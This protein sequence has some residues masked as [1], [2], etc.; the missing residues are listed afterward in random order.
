MKENEIRDVKKREF[1]KKGLFA[2][3]AG[4]LA[5]LFSKIG[6]V[7]AERR[8]MTPI[9]PA[10]GGTGNAFTKFTGPT[11]TEKTFTL[12]DASS[13]I[14]VQSGALGTP[15]SGTLSNCTGLPAAQGAS[16]VLLSTITASNS[17][18]VDVETTF[19]STYDCYVLKLSGFYGGTGGDIL[20]AR[21]KIGGSYITT[22]TYPEHTVLTNSGAI[23]YSGTENAA[24][25]SIQLTD[26]L[27][28][29][30]ATTADLDIYIYHPSDTT[31]K[32]KINWIGSYFKHT[33]TPAGIAQGVGGN[34]GTDALTGIR[35][36]MSAGN[37]TAGTARLYGFKNT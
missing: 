2:L 5:A 13:T 19:D 18:T 22:T 35:I 26:A 7:N 12:P 10:S 20:M 36:F 15:S 16:M 17:A 21:F 1:I 3:A 31:S 30:S 9:A 28:T 8:S 25:S 24:S 32:K 37:I 33:G 14:I 4:G 34:T 23:T 29:T 6:F 27:N 11:T